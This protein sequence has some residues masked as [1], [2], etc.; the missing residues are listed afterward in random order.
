MIVDTNPSSPWLIG[1][2]RDRF[3]HEKENKML[4]N[5][6]WGVKRYFHEEINVA[7]VDVNTPEGELMKHTFDVNTFPHILLV[8]PGG[9]YHEMPWVS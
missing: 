1:F 4:Y 8:T 3:K 6:L 7:W 5:T 9:G 2:T